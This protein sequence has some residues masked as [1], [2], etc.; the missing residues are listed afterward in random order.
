[1]FLQ[2]SNIFAVSNDFK[3]VFITNKV[4]PINHI[5]LDLYQNSNYHF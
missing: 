3:Q 1:M 4:E 2:L 5:K